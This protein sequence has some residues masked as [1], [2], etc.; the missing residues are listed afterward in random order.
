VPERLTATHSCPWCREVSSR[1]HITH[2]EAAFV[3]LDAAARRSG[4]NLT[5]VPKTHV[6]TL[7]ELPA[8]E[9]AAL[10]AGLSRAADD[11]RRS[12]GTS[13]VDIQAHPSDGANSGAHL[14]FDL[15]PE[16]VPAPPSLQKPSTL[17]SAGRPGRGAAR[18]SG[19]VRP[20][21]TPVS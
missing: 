17:A 12:A 19:G 10:L 20:A 4:R 1:G 8:P 15:V 9:V 11:L 2:E 7:T 3:I 14:Y 13:R 5:L 18:P 21:K 16:P 6:G